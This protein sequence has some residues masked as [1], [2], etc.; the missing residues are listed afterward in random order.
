MYLSQAFTPADELSILLLWLCSLSIS[1]SITIPQ[2]LL[3]SLSPS[4]SFSLSPLSL[5]LSLCSGRVPVIRCFVHASEI[6][7]D[8]EGG[9]FLRHSIIAIYG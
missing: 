2:S 5:F 8:R 3:L 6:E 1:L 9:D 4:L 7:K